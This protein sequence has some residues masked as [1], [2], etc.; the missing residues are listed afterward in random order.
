MYR[1]CGKGKAI[2][3]KSSEVGPTQPGLQVTRKH[4]RQGLGQQRRDSDDGPGQAPEPQISNKGSKA[5]QQRKGSLVNKRCWHSWT[6]VWKT[7][8]DPFLTPWAASNSR[9]ITGLRVRDRLGNTQARGEES[10]V[11]TGWVKRPW[12]RQRFLAKKRKRQ[13]EFYQNLKL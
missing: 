6:G 2:L 11:T 1:G 12:R 3:E 13:V 7:K 10:S 4:G 9:W 8:P 5:I